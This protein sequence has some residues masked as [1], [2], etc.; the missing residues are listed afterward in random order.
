MS[1][2]VCKDLVKVYGKKG[3][4]T[5]LNLELESGKIYGLIGR[6]GV[7]KTTLLS[8]MSNQNPATEGEVT[9]DG[10]NIW[11]NRK[12]LERICFSRELNI[13]AESGLINYTVKKYL[14]TAA[15]YFV[16]WDKELAARLVAQFE[17]KGK[18]KLGKLSKGMLSMV[19]IIVAL[20]MGCTRKTVL[21]SYT[22]RMMVGVGLAYGLLLLLNGLEMAVGSVLYAGYPLELELDYLH[23]WQFALGTLVGVPVVCLFIGS[24]YSRFG[25]KAFVP[26][27]FI[28]IA[29]CMSLPRLTHAEG[30]VGQ[31]LQSVPGWGWWSI[32]GA[33]VAAMVVTVVLLNKKQ[34]VR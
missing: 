15:C 17:L 30:A 16:H 21:W 34:A 1:K 12:A 7:G 22:L 31:F 11:E 13:S 24:L 18:T 14:D 23:D 5:G 8:I 19:T 6:N 28:W 10:E 32:A 26:M 33:A 4:L 25:R 27:Y 9:L 20:A 2:L 3:V 29:G